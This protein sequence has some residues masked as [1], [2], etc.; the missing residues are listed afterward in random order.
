MGC[1]VSGVCDFHNALNNAR[2]IL[3]QGPRPFVLYRRE[4]VSGVSGTGVVAQGVEFQDGTVALRW[5]SAWPTSV[6]FHERG[7]EAVKAVH[8]HNGS[9]VVLYTDDYRIPKADPTVWTELG[10]YIEAAIEDG[11]PIDARDLMA[12]YLELRRRS[13]GPIADAQGWNR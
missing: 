6:V 10:G 1:C 7:M 9:T 2:A 3:D 13:R 5:L 12:Y 11:K 4:D 8:G